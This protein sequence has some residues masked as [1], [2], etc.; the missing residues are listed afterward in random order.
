VKILWWNPGIPKL[1][2]ANKREKKKI[3]L[4]N[5]FRRWMNKTIAVEVMRASH[6][7]LEKVNKMPVKLVRQPKTI[8]FVCVFENRAC[9]KKI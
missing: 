3:A 9:P 4:R 8:H 5:S 6:D 2:P 1:R 7:P